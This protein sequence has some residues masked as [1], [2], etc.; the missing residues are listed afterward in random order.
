MGNIEKGQIVN[1]DMRKQ[2]KFID[3][4]GKGGT[5]RALLFK[6]ETTDM[7]FAIKKYETEALSHTP[8]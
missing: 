7:L 3:N 5:G 1:F 4:L 2:F 6:D 8:R